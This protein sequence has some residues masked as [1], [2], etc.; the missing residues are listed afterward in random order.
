MAS[1]GSRIYFRA[2]RPDG[3]IESGHLQARDEEDAVRQLRQ[4][5]RVPFQIT[6]ADGT[7]PVAAAREHRPAAAVFGQRLDL[8]RFFGDLSVMLASGF[9]VDI[10]LHAVAD[11]ETDRLQSRRAAEI[12]GRITEGQSVAEAFAPLP[13]VTDDVLA[14][15]AS[16]ENSG[17]IDVVVADLAAAYARRAARRREVLEALM[18][19]AFLVLV[20][21][22]AFLLLS[23]YL[24]PALQPV[25]ENAGVPAPLVVRGLI[26]FGGFVTGYGLILLL[27]LASALALLAASLRTRSGAARVAELL[28]RLP[29]V[30]GFLRGT[31]NARYLNTMA[32]LL[33]NGVPMLEA[34][35]L[36]SDTAAAASQRASLLAAR[37]RVSDGEPFW[38]A[39]GGARQFPDF[40]VSLVRLGEQ[41]NNLAPMLARAGATI[42]AQMQRR[43]ARVLTFL[44]PAITLFLGLVV[45]GL[46]ISVMTTLLSI[47]EIAIQ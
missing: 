32:L 42:E 8:A 43:V 9:T 45:G 16:G 39:I 6:R 15:L 33:G 44:T 31:A 14:L 47:N 21:F 29:A 35:L 3:Q 34:M 25:F 23:L 24:A 22:F 18:Y 20:M 19:P 46:V 7:R 27:V 17:R 2:Y 5:G 10:A 12:H 40:V 41:S 37:Q 1:A 38:R 28:L 13:E 30:A 36:A 4:S 11:A 26:A